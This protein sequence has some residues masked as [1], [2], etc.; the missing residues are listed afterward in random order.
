MLRLIQIGN[1]LPWTYPVDSTSVFLPGMI[2]QLKVMGND[3]V[4]GLSD[5][6]AP[7]GILDDVRSTA[8]TRPSVDEI[9]VIV[10][11]ASQQD[12]YGRW[13]SVGDA[14][15]ELENPNI[16]ASSFVADYDDLI[17]NVV[18]GVLTLPA[19]SFLN[20]DSG[21]GHF[22][23]VKTIVNYVYQVPDL[24]G[25]DT[26]IGSNRVTIWFTR[27]LY[28]TDQYDTTQRYAVNTPLFVNEEGKL[29]SRQAT[30]NHPAVALCTAPPS[31]LVGN[32]E[33]MWL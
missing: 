31:A 9:V 1:N 27:G 10:P 19:G 13:I 14:K 8:F 21:S 26:T 22:D 17:V 23:S 5:G 15:K 2:G 28:A 33:F 29:T 12:A 30:A 11:A 24:P 25:D 6:L 20:Y 16:T 32:L 7:L 3:I 4:I 18:N